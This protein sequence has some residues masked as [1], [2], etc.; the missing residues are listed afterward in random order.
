MTPPEFPYETLV[1][2]LGGRRR[3][4]IV[5]RIWDRSEGN[6]RDLLFNATVPV[7]YHRLQ[8]IEELADYYLVEAYDDQPKRICWILAIAA[9]HGFFVEI[10]YENAKGEFSKRCLGDIQFVDFE[11]EVPYLPFFY[12]EGYCFLRKERRTFRVSRIFSVRL[13]A[14]T[15][16]EYE[17]KEFPF[18]E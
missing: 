1:A 3:I 11:D 6:V 9:R 13:I 7:A 8:I 10:N 12:V 2:I 18:I 15:K 17:K 4:L 16:S 5:E 14:L